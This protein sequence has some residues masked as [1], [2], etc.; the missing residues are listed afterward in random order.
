MWEGGEESEIDG[1]EQWEGG[2][3]RLSEGRRVGEKKWVEGKGWWNK[4][5]TEGVRYRR[6]ED[7]QKN[8]RQKVE[9]R[10]E[11]RKEVSN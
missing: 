9:E 1:R 4:R 11:G 3:K 8:G 2:S 6:G 10:E 5:A 7:R